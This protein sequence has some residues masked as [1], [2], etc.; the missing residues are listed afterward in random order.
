LSA[1]LSARMVSYSWG[2]QTLLKSVTLDVELG[3]MTVLI[4]P[5]GAGKSTL[6]RLMS[7]EL[8][9]TSGLIVNEGEDLARLSPAG[10]AVR[11]AVM[12]QTIQVSSPFRVHEIVRLGLDG[13]G[14]V[15]AQARAS[16]VERCL[17]VADVL[18]LASRPYAAL[19]G[20]EQRRVQFARVLAQI[21]AARTVHDRQAL[22]LDE[23]VANLDL[24]HQLALL[25]AAQ[26]AAARGV[27]VL[28]V[29]HDLN[30]AARYADMLAL[31]NDGAIVACGEPASVQTSRLLSGVFAIDR[32][33]G[34]TLTSESPLVMPSRWL[35]GG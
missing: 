27:A 8:R 25:D 7:G 4:G 21:E 10:L 14:R 20:G 23:P 17:D 22:L 1:F 16:I 29:L 9:P 3:R 11:C 19:S 24:P 34:T 26:G 18:P 13:I 30:L 35:I 6:V 2:R 12:T 33:V 5:N 28:A 32:A 31:M 15:N